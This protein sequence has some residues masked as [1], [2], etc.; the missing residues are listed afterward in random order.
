MQF[1]SPLQASGSSLD[2]KL[3]EIEIQAATNSSA[4]LNGIPADPKVPADEL[5]NL[6]V[7]ALARG[8]RTQ[9]GPEFA[10]KTLGELQG[11]ALD[12]FASLLFRERIE[13]LLTAGE[14]ERAV[15]LARA[16]VA[17]RPNDIHVQI[18]LARALGESDSTLGEAE[19]LLLRIASKRPRDAEVLAW[20]G[21]VERKSGNVRGSIEHFEAALALSSDQ[22]DALVGLTKALVSIGKPGE[23][24]R[25]LE[26]YLAFDNPIDGTVALELAR[27]IEN[28]EST[29]DQ[30]VALG[31]RALRFG[32]GQSAVDFLAEIDP[33]LVAPNESEL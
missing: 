33:D 9:S 13:N 20:L 8:L 23:A 16:A 11:Q 30:R 21:C 31:L 3:I 4:D 14:T 25:R 22:H 24:R 7:R 2:S 17:D 19:A 27:M 15:G 29:K 12:S 28:G 1:T 26:S 6:A 18:A 10:A 32:A 5:R